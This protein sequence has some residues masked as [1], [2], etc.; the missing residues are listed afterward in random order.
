MLADHREGP[1][2]LAPLDD[3]RLQGFLNPNLICDNCNAPAWRHDQEPPL[4]CPGFVPRTPG[5]ELH[6]LRRFLVEIG[7]EDQVEVPVTRQELTE[8]T[9]RV[10]RIEV[11][12]GQLIPSNEASPGANY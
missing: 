6:N 12:L 8:L 1:P 2:L 7:A 9:E 5:V 3:Q 4:D 11:T 10:T